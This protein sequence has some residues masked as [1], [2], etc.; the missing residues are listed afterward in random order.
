V[1]HCHRS[2]TFLPEVAAHEG[3]SR[4]Q[5]V[6]ALVRKAGFVGPAMPALRAALRLVRYRSSARSLSHGAW[7]SLSAAAAARCAAPFGIFFLGCTQGA[8][9]EASYTPF[10]AAG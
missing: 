2:A 8:P 1:A 9:P 10:G 4:Q 3:W 5:T 7:R 6:D